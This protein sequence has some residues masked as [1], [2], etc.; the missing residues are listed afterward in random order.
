MPTIYNSYPSEN[1]LTEKIN[2]FQKNTNLQHFILLVRPEEQLYISSFHRRCFENQ[3]TRLTK[4][5]LLNLE[6]QWQNNDNW[7]DLLLRL[8]I[9]FPDINLG[10]ASIMNK[11][12]LDDSIQ[13][14]LNFSMMQYWD[15]EIFEY[16]I[17]KNYLLI[18]GFQT[19]RDLQ[20][21][22]NLNCKI[23]KI[24]PVKQTNSSLNLK[25]FSSQMS[26]IAAGG[27]FISDL[28]KFK[29]LGYHSI[30]IGSKGYYK[31]QFDPKIIKWLKNNA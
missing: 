10:S 2:F 20:D 25:N 7:L 13:V 23:G 6:I 27:L 15:K 29:S 16:S 1:T 14:G 26:F 22:F 12:S 11:K 28:R 18:P 8:R 4:L 21:A 31:E 5:G 9:K 30:V 19:D 24:F 3:I 17:S